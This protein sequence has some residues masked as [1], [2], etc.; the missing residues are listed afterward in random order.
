ASAGARPPPGPPARP[1]P[2]RAAR[3]SPPPRSGAPRPPPAT[4]EPVL[5]CRPPLLENLGRDGREATSGPRANGG[6]LA[7]MRGVREC[8]G[9]AV[10]R[11]IRLSPNRSAVLTPPRA[12][13]TFQDEGSDPR[14]GRPRAGSADDGP[15]AGGRPG[16]R[17]GDGARQGARSGPGERAVPGGRP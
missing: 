2:R 7:R 14:G 4:P 6:K 10:W 12:R 11:R 3:P 13:R 16:T 9:W 5:S 8:G 17:G 15:A 1:A